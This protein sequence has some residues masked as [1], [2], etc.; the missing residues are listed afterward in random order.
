MQFHCCTNDAWLQPWISMNKWIAGEPSVLHASMDD[1]K[2][3]KMQ[4]RKWVSINWQEIK[5]YVRTR[6]CYSKLSI[7][8]HTW[9]VACSILEVEPRWSCHN[10][11]SKPLHPVTKLFPRV[12]LIIN[13]FIYVFYISYLSNEY[14]SDAMFYQIKTWTNITYMKIHRYHWHGL[15]LVFKFL[16]KNKGRLY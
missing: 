7:I 14:V 9:S 1:V 8:P 13:L 3:I 10:L 2:T 6:T 5:L 15:L 16:I 11:E 4:R 12:G